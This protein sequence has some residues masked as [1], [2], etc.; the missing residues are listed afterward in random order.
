MRRSRFKRKSLS[1]VLKPD[2]APG[3]LDNFKFIR[4]YFDFRYSVIDRYREQSLTVDL[5]LCALCYR[6]GSRTAED[7]VTTEGCRKGFEG[8]EAAGTQRQR[9][10]EGRPGRP[11][12]QLC[13]LQG[14][15]CTAIT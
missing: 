13:R 7:S 15:S 10:E 9:P 5:L 2:R 14:T 8:K 11:R 12:F 4:F 3:P 6:Y 1:V